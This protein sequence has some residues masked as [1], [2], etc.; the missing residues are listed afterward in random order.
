MAYKIYIATP[1][2]ARQ[3][4]TFELKKIMAEH[5]IQ[6]LSE[7]IGCD[8]RFQNCITCGFPD[9]VTTDDEARSMGECIQAVIEA[10]AIYLDHGWQASKGCNLE[11]RA[12]KIYGKDIYEHDRL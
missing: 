9:V 3:E 8:D 11:Y 7:I 1:V 2:N 5:R 6:A 12:A 4:K 10:D